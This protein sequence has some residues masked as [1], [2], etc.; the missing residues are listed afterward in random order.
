MFDIESGFHAT[1]ERRLVF[2]LILLC[3][4]ITISHKCHNC[5]I[6]SPPS[7][8]KMCF[9]V[10]YERVTNLRSFFEMLAASF[11]FMRLRVFFGSIL[12]KMLKSKSW[13][14]FRRRADLADFSCLYSYR[15]DDPLAELT[16]AGRLAATLH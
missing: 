6:I 4:L 14:V 3:A 11:D 7:A 8:V 13:K 10:N 5:S 16:P 12:M 9:S 2:L 15:A 1:A